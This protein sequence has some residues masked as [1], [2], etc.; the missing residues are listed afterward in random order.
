MTHVKSGQDGDTGGDTIPRDERRLID[1]TTSG[2]S[3]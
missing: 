2:F 1:G 3:A